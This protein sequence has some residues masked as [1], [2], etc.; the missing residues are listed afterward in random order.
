MDR[1]ATILCVCK[2]MS[3]VENIILES[4]TDSRINN[5][6]LSVLNLFAFWLCCKL[7][8]N[9]AFFQAYILYT[10]WP[11]LGPRR[12]CHIQRPHH[13]WQVCSFPQGSNTHTPTPKICIG[14]THIQAES[15]SH[16]WCSSTTLIQDINSTKI[17]I[18]NQVL[19]HIFHTAIFYFF[20]FQL[21][22]SK[23]TMVQ[24]LIW[25]YLGAALAYLL[26]ALNKS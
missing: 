22:I 8:A 25:W 7:S 3:F 17:Y 6:L 21:S 26:P 12:A 23:S 9:I 4:K 13:D 18:L 20:F 10:T 2:S 11:K 1:T 5:Q 19:D 14:Q 15:F 16:P 24:T